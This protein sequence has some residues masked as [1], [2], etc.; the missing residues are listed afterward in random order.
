MTFHL[1]FDKTSK[2]SRTILTIPVEKNGSFEIS[3]SNESLKITR[4]GI[5]QG[6]IEFDSSDDFS[7]PFHICWNVMDGEMLDTI[8]PDRQQLSLGSITWKNSDS[9]ISANYV[10]K[11]RVINGATFHITNLDGSVRRANKLFLDLIMF[12]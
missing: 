3:I 2:M 1:N 8:F 12:E 6:R 7:Q 11:G 10:K 5:R 4:V 9:H